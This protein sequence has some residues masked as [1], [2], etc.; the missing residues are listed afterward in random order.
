MSHEI[1]TP[2]NAVIGMSDLLLH[3]GL[4]ATQADFAEIIHDSASNLLDI[5]NDIL[6]FSKI[7]A[8]KLRLELS[9]FEL[10][11]LIEGTTEL[12]AEK[13]R[14]KKLSLLTF[15][16]PKL[17]QQFRGDAG[18]IRQILLNLISNSIKFTESGEIII[19][20]V[21]DKTEG[22]NVFV[23]FA[24][25]D[26]G[27]GI[28]P[29]AI[30]RIFEPFVQADNTTRLAHGGTG[31]GLSICRHL[32]ENM[33]GELLAKSTVEKGST[34]S[35]IVPL[36]IANDLAIETAK[37]L[38]GKKILLVGLSK[39]AA[40]IF[41]TYLE[42]WHATCKV[43]NTEAE[44]LEIITTVG[45]KKSVDVVIVSSQ[46]NGA[47]TELFASKL[48]KL[49][50]KNPVRVIL[51]NA[52]GERSPQN[53]TSNFAGYLRAPLRQ[54]H[55]LECI[56]NE[57]HA[58]DSPPN[59]RGNRTSLDVRLM[60]AKSGAESPF[61]GPTIL[62]AEDNAVNQKVAL[63]QLSRLGYN[64]H[65]V[66]NGL[67]V[68][69][70]LQRIP[71]AL[72]FMDCQMPELDGYQTAGEI[73]KR[74]IIS[75]THIPI[76]AMTAHA[77]EGDREKCIEAG[78]DD[79]ISKPVVKD[80]LEALLKKWLPRE[81]LSESA[82]IQV[83]ADTTDALSLFSSPVKRGSLSDAAKG[84]DLRIVSRVYFMTA[85]R[86]LKDSTDAIIQK[87]FRALRALARDLEI[88]STSF[89]AAEMQQLCK[90]LTTSATSQ[91]VTESKVIVEALK[92]A[93]ES[94]KNLV[95]EKSATQ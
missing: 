48:K 45:D 5:I 67:E 19:R 3:S 6:D 7:E 46:F 18:R 60:D 49:A 85:D 8:G 76:I 44:A 87:D 31:L 27:V 35:F 38:A 32:V 33:G 69:D 28:P 55:L 1:R 39:T 9:D 78:M 15:I 16:A 41:E 36:E 61:A 52:C 12:L 77:M 57:K 4:T 84:A 63:W 80:I 92:L 51:F 53:D 34:F 21:I 40:L 30:D 62:V 90:E 54:S 66:A 82:P 20:A 22:S 71:Y 59:T 95:A 23:K 14:Q 73:R 79:Y 70:A 58:L 47:N 93:L 72:V 94:V 83:L 29:E 64:A 37:P 50:P 11:P 91:N 13:A 89:E 75:G 25:T 2:M 88:Q 65:A 74:E 56:A 86:I 68:L 26:T 17:T 24:V 81:S 42:A 43:A 10:V